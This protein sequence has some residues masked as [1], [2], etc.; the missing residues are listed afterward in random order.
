MNFNWKSKKENFELVKE[1]VEERDTVINNA[2]HITRYLGLVVPCRNIIMA[3]YYYVG[4]YM[5]YGV[6]L[7]YLAK[8]SEFACP[9]PR[10]ISREEIDRNFPLLDSKY[11]WGV[12]VYDG[13]MDDTR[14]LME[15]FLTSAQ[16]DYKKGQKGATLLNYTKL[17]KFLKDKDGKIIGVEVY[18]KVNQ[19]TMTLKGKVVVN[20]TG[21]FTDHI[22]KLDNPSAKKRMV[23]SLG[24]HIMLDSTFCSRQ[25]GIL[26]P[27]TSD[28]RVLF[29]VPWLQGTIVGTTDVI[30]EEPAAHPTPTPECM[31]FLKRETS[32]IYP[33]LKE[34]SFES[35]VRSKW[36]G[37]RPLCSDKDLE[38]GDTKGSAKDISRKHVIMESDSGLITVV[39]GKWT[40]F[41]RMG[42]DVL[43]KILQ[44]VKPTLKA[45]PEEYSTKSLRFIGDFREAEATRAFSKKKD[46]EIYSA[47][48]AK[49][50]FERH[51]ALGL[52]L[53]NHLTRAYGIRSLDIL[54]IIASDP[55][56]A[57]KIHPSF[58]VTKAEIVYQ[59]RNEM[60][61]NVFDLI[62]R[63]NRLAFLD[64]Q[65]TLD[66][67]PNI[68]DILGD[69]FKWS[70]QTKQDN[71]KQALRIF[72]QMAF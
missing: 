25:M 56:L 58:E 38:V 59:I 14:L 26:I 63:R 61:V 2:P 21:N 35:H 50:L 55:R 44:K 16:D 17:E 64:K 3:L 22:R 37:I 51:S 68:I 20:A 12:A 24:T 31:E 45:M 52:P 65:S 69:E 48:L 4:L 60:V 62:L 10:I 36:S 6:S 23:H 47:S 8:T 42:E 33:V 34:Q 18:D 57:T 15:A 49:E 53:I 5:Y 40:I 32:I 19:Q 54:D 1:S 27:K 28:G 41:R 71:Y 67:L 13:E 43:L 70:V 11:Q 29:I 7:R 66:C 46:Q 72:S 9:A 30:V 39:G